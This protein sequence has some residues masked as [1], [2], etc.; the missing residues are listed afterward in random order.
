[1]HFAQYY[2]LNYNQAELDFVDISLDHDFPLFFDPYA[3]SISEDAWS[4]Q[5][6][7]DIVSFFETALHCV[8]SGNEA[9]GRSLFNHLHEPNETCLGWSRGR[10]QGRGIGRHQAGQIYQA[11]ATS[12]AAQTGTHFGFDRMRTLYLWYW[13]RQ[14]I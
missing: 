1:M 13:S 14:D 8:R 11:L 9:R 2:G 12:A 4:L 7:E 5:C 6:H 3:F 10:P